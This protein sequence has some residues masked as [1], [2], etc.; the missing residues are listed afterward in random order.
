[1]CGQASIACL[2]YWR[3]CPSSWGRLPVL[4]LSKVICM[5]TSGMKSKAQTL[6][7]LLHI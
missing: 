1:M 4:R 5:Q 6:V 2:L 7:T 3:I